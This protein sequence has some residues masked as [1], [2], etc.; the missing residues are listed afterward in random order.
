MKH[1]LLYLGM[2]VTISNHANGWSTRNATFNGLTDE[3]DTEV[4]LYYKISKFK[5]EFV[6][7]NVNCQK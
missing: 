2:D 1:C 6:I 5:M 7:K 4:N 3:D